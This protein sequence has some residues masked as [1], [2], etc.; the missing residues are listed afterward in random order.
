[1]EKITTEFYQISIRGRLAFG[2]TCLEKLVIA[3][4][5]DHPLL[6][7]NVFPKIWEFTSSDDLSE[8]EEN[9]NEIDPVCVLDDEVNTKLKELYNN[10]PKDIV[11]TIGDVISIGTENLY[12]GTNNN[13]PSTLEPLNSIIKRMIKL[14]IPLPD[15]MPF[16]KSSFSEF[17]GWG[18]NRERNYYQL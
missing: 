12:G 9:I 6:Q 15:I 14:N 2:M 4:E 8:W 16:K 18:E 3:L 7:T 17:H 5:S 13:S 1:M 10:L 11:S